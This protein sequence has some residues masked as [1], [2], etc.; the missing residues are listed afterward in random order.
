MKITV[1]LLLLLLCFSS[2][3]QNDCPEAITVCGDMSYIGLEAEGIGDIQEIGP[4]ACSQG[5]SG[6]N[7]N[8]TIWL[9]VLIK[10]GGTLGFILTPISTDLVVDFDF[11]L[12]GPNVECDALG[13]ALRCSTT[14]PGNADLDYNTTGMNEES[15]DFSEGPGADGDAFVNWITV[16]D[17]DILYLVIDRPHG[18]SDFSMEWTGTATF[19]EAPYFNNPDDIG[20]DME[21]CDE[22]GVYDQSTIFDLTTHHTLLVGPQTD[23]ELTYHTS[24]NDA[25]TGQD[26]LENPEEFANTSNPQTIYLRMTN[27]VTGCNTI[28]IFTINIPVT[29]AEAEDMEVCDPNGTGFFE[30]DL[31]QNDEIITGGNPNAEVTYYASQEDAENEMNPIGPLFENETAYTSQ[32]IWG[33]LELEGESCFDLAPFEITVFRIPVF[34][35]PLNVS[36]DLLLCDPDG[37]G[38]FFDLTTY[39]P[40]FRGT[41][42]D[43]AFSYYEDEEGM[44]SDTPI[45]MPEMYEAVTNPQIIYVEAVNLLNPECTS[46]IT[47]VIKTPVT[48]GNPEDLTLC[49]TDENGHREFDLSLND[50]AIKDGITGATVLYY[51]SQDDAIN[52]NTPIGPIYQNN[53][54]YETQTIW[55]RM[56]ITG[57]D[58]Y[59]IVSF[60]ISITPLPLI[61]TP[62]NLPPSLRLCDEDGVDNQSTVFDLTIN[63]AVITGAQDNITFSY[64]ETE[65]DITADTPIGNPAAFVNTSNP[66]TLYMKLN[67]SDTGCAIVRP[68]TIETYIITAGIPQDLK[69]CN[70]NNN[71]IREFDLSLNDNAI[72]NGNTTSQV[73]YF[74][75]QA[76]AESN[77][78][79]IGPLYEN[80]TPYTDETIWARI[81]QT[82]GTCYDIISFEIILLPLP[83]FNNPENIDLDLS[84]C[85]D[86]GVDDQSDTFNLTVHESMLRGNQADISFIYYA[87]AEDL[88]N[89][90]PIAAPWGYNNI[91]NPQTVYVVIANDI[92]GC[93]FG[94]ETF[95]IEIINPVEAGLPIDLEACDFNE[96]GF[97]I[98]NLSLNDLLIIQGVPFRDVSYYATF[99]DAQ[100]GTNPLPPFYQN[101]IPYAT[102]TIWARIEA[103]NG[104][105]GY[106]VT[107]FTIVVN[108]LPE[109]NYNINTEDFTLNDNS[110]AII[111]NNQENFEYSMDGENYTDI[112]YFDNLEPGLYTVFIRSKDGCSSAQEEVVLLNYPKFFT[113]N[114]DGIND[115]WQVFYLYFLPH[116]KVTIFDRYGKLVSSFWGSSIGWDGMYN[117]HALPS[118]DY[119]FLLELE[120]G[121]VIKGHFAMVR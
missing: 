100:D 87:S 110:I 43:I 102:E 39:E 97:Q 10:D 23:V 56:E 13:T 72:K 118:T 104:C 73:T 28:E 2:R 66:Q 65:D 34:N 121:R 96:N 9:R 76:D 111:M 80:Q 75:S 116:A 109:I 55:A 54:A 21:L 59:D 107:S 85:D 17:D 16:E 120:S 41:Q 101:Q 106:A 105:L 82:N 58:C 90:I 46:T 42:T 94:P 70:T 84:Q 81:Q 78:N 30:F 3:A 11:W 51:A 8:N 95:E 99:E 92:T 50:D 18:F 114:G 98:F 27:T 64:Y 52:E 89:N 47:F 4:N 112:P 35:N 115:T 32:T 31:S 57:E 45:T 20:L 1:T 38:N 24:N 88:V 91:S 40:M 37:S 26:P 119:W 74:T 68:F 12:F 113:P 49:D 7:E 36:I 93:T 60:T 86:D 6:D 108:P 67:D 53:V 61:N 5:S 29:S 83:V 22:D 71:G 63:E 19:H 77:L 103:T 15:E 79:P 14:N 44:L 33:R 69:L 62:G 48:A 25:L 117:G